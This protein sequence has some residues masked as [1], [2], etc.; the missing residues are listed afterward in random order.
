ML[1]QCRRDPAPTQRIGH[2]GTIDIQGLLP[3]IHIGQVCPITIH[4]GLELM[5]CQVMVNGQRLAHRNSSVNSRN[6]FSLLQPSGFS[7]LHLLSCRQLSRAYQ[8]KTCEVTRINNLDRLAGYFDTHTSQG[9]PLSAMHVDPAPSGN[10][11]MKNYGLTYQPPSTVRAARK[12]LLSTAQRT[13]KRP[14]TDCFL[15]KRYRIDGRLC[16]KQKKTLAACLASVYLLQVTGSMY[17]G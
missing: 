6:P 7:I 4:C 12:V 9:L 17:A 11:R 16:I 15:T 10:S 3:K 13:A 8:A 14:R 1:G 5:A 2:E